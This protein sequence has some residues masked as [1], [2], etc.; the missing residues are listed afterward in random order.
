[1]DIAIVAGINVRSISS[2]RDHHSLITLELSAARFSSVISSI[3]SVRTKQQIIS[4]RSI[5]GVLSQ[6]TL[7][8]VNTNLFLQILPSRVRA[9]LLLWL[10]LPKPT[11]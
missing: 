1:M 11:C 10:L 9:D 7:I 6:Q 3:L 4:E 2:P 5:P 8:G